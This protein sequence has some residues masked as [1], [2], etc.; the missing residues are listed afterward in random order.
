MTQPIPNPPAAPAP[1]PERRLLLYRVLGGLAIAAIAVV[2]TWLSPRWP[3]VATVAAPACAY[4]GKLVGVPVDAITE[5]ALRLMQPERVAA[6][7]VRAI[8]S[9]PPERSTVATRRIIA[10]IHPPAPGPGIPPIVDLIPD[11]ETTSTGERLPPKT[12]P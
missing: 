5:F 1:T 11:T 8:Q 9:M 2:S 6:L 3:W 7:A 12:E 4:I 10:S